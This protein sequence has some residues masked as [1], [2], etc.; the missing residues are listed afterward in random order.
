MAERIPVLYRIVRVLVRHAVRI[1]YRRWEIEGE[2]HIPP[3][4]PLLLAI[5]KP[6]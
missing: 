4:G 6:N 1:F 3:T 5:L 2:E